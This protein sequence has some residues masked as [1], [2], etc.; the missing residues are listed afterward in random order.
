MVLGSIWGDN[1]V[2]SYVFYNNNSFFDFRYLNRC[3]KDR[4]NG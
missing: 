4:L 3:L 2:S 1:E